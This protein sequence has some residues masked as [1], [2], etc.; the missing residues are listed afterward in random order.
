MVDRHI[1]CG[2]GIHVFGDLMLY[3]YDKYTTLLYAVGIY[4]INRKR[5]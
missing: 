2:N 1:Q 5:I 3:S 4:C